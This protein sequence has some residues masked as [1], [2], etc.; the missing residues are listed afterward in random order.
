MKIEVVCRGE[1]VDRLVEAILDAASTGCRGDGLVFVL[2]VED[3][4][5]VR[6]RQRGAVALRS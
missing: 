5:K 2:P 3:V 1:D 6:T 4:V